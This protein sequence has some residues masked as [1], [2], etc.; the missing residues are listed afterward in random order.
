MDSLKHLQGVFQIIFHGFLGRIPAKY[1][2]SISYFRN[3]SGDTLRNPSTYSLFTI[4][5]RRFFKKKVFNGHFWIFSKRF[6]SEN[7]WKFRSQ[8]DSG[9]S[10]RH[11]AR[12]F[13]MIVLDIGL[14]VFS[15]NLFSD[16]SRNTYGYTINEFLLKFLQEFQQRFHLGFH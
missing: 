1:V 4:F 14:L 8:N 16:S 13:S 15:R 3:S 7:L 12:D 10:F 11:S 6:G 5:F 2:S 9:N